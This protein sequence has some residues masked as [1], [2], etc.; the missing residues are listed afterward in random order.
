MSPPWNVTIH[1]E[2]MEI[3]ANVVEKC[4]EESHQIRLFSPINKGTER[5][6]M[7]ISI[8]HIKNQ[9]GTEIKECY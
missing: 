8:I 5:L 6:A 1:W 2:G 7:Y 9:E 3:I 4:E